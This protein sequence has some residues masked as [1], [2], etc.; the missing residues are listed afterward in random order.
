[1]TISESVVFF[2]RK[3]VEE[4]EKQIQ[5]MIKEK[6]NIETEKNKLENECESIRYQFLNQIIVITEF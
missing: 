1:M 3:S 6:T 2:F 5:D 4:K